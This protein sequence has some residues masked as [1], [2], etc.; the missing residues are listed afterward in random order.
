[1]KNLKHITLSTSEKISF[2][3]NLSTMLGA[4]IS[5]IEIIDSLMEDAKGNTRTVLQSLKDDINQGKR[6]YAAFERFPQVFDRVTINIIRASEEAGTLDAT[7]VDLKDTIKKEQEFIDKVRSAFIYP[8][9]ILVMFLGVL[10][11]IL[12]FV[13]PRIAVV[14]SR[15]KTELPLPTKILIFLSDLILKQTIP[16]I[17]GIA[18][19]V[20]GFVF[21]I[22]INRKGVLNIIFSLPLVTNL[23]RYIDLTRFTRSLHLLLSAGIPIVTALDLTKDVVMKKSVH[24]MIKGCEEMVLAGKPF[25][26]GLKNRRNVAPRIMIKIVEAGE[27]SGGLDKAL[28]DISIHLDYQV[29][30]TLNTITTLLEPLLLMVVGI[31]VGSMMLSII[32]PIY[33]LIGSV[34]GAR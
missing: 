29:T 34:G 23:I 3:S 13:V 7:L 26:E 21:L 14:F 25:S 4:G 2:I 19:L 33:G 17:L 20:T 1:M 5:I 22:K 11:L 32:A 18:V 28:K 6:L 30:S 27:K 8:T 9:L 16:L 24:D 12:T 31:M 15:L 10:L